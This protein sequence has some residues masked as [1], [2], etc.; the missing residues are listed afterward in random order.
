MVF[1]HSDRWDDSVTTLAGWVRDG[2]LLAVEEV[3]DGIESCPDALAGLYRGE[4]EG[5]RVIRLA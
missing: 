1:D 4:N 2:S 5:K 3:L